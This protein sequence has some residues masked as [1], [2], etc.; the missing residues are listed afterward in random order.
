MHTWITPSHIPF[1]GII[2]SHIPFPGITPS[3][4]PFPGITPSHIPFPGITPSHIPFPG[5]PHSHVE[6]SYTIITKLVCNIQMITVEKKS[7]TNCNIWQDCGEVPCGTNSFPTR[8]RLQV[9]DTCYWALFWSN[10]K[11]T[12]GVVINLREGRGWGIWGST[13]STILQPTHQHGV[14]LDKMLQI[15]SKT[16]NI[17]R[18]YVN[19][20]LRPSSYQVTFACHL[21]SLVTANVLS[22]SIFEVVN[23]FWPLC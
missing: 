6:K 12:K 7:T 21:L 18:C 1:P 17:S 8:V 22:L 11:W 16:A 20:I 2:P 4:I 9:L 14:Q 3:H 5:M 10:L 15:S 13:E 19:V 23:I